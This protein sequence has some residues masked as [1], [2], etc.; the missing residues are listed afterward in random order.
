[1]KS[2][3]SNKRRYQKV[4]SGENIKRNTLRSEKRG[5][6]FRNEM[7]IQRQEQN[8]FEVGN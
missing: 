6:C 3:R 5:F 2:W 4:A 7:N 1:V 8:G